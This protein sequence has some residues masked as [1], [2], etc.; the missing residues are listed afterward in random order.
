MMIA[1]KVTEKTIPECVIQ[2]LYGGDQ[3]TGDKPWMQ[4][5]TWD[6]ELACKLITLNYPVDLKG[7]GWD[8][9][10]KW[11][12]DKW[13]R[14]SLTGV[15]HIFDRA[16]GIAKSSIHAGK[17]KE[18]DTPANWLKWAQEKGYDV[19]H[20]MPADAPAA[21]GETKKRQRQD[22]LAVE[23]D[24]IL[25]AMKSQTPAKVMAELRKKIDKPYT[26]ILRNVGDGIEWENDRGDVKTLTIIML[27][28]RIR[29][30]K[31]TGL[32]QG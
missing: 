8:S 9:A 16:L 27:G 12:R 11:P 23:L 20:L 25:V 10:K 32:S 3:Y 19:A 24:E 13:G 2:S 18:H 31:K 5:D 26:C 15:M 7:S 14:G 17:V 28:E 30:W 29:E 22:A 1:K 6:V 4:F 21:K